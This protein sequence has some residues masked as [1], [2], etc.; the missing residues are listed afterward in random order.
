[1]LT[2]VSYIIEFKEERPT[3]QHKP[4]NKAELRLTTCYNQI[5][6][7]ED[8]YVTLQSNETLFYPKNTGTDFTVKLPKHLKLPRN[9]FQM[10]VAEFY[11]TRPEPP[12]DENGNYRE[13]NLNTSTKFIIICCA[14]A[15]DQV[16]GG[17]MVPML[18]Y[19]PNPI[20]YNELKEYKFSGIQYAGVAAEEIS[21]IRIKLLDDQLR[22]LPVSRNPTSVVLHFRPRPV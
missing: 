12:K 7:M 8:F 15:E 13:P 19:L 1:M 10:G 14:C 18:R 22:P 2:S 9:T 4:I 16:Y 6:K 11:Y 21:A 17:A 3:I 5:I 20:E